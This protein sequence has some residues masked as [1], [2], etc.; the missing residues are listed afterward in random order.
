MKKFWNTSS[1][2]AL[3]VFIILYVIERFFPEYLSEITH[4]KGI[5]VLYYLFASLRF[6]KLELKEK[7]QKIQELE[8][9][10][11]QKGMQ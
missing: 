10:L 9:K 1:I 6:F 4:H 11:K 3:L 7:N 8:I 2:V 5:F